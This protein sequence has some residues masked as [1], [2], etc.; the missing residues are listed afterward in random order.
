MKMVDY[1]F[2]RKTP[3]VIQLWNEHKGKMKA[4]NKSLIFADFLTSS[5]LH[6]HYFIHVSGVD[7]IF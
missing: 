3:F 7:E 4:K 6:K 1:Y 2:W 5:L